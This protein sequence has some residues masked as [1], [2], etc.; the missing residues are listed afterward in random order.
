MV[1]HGEQKFYKVWPWSTILAM[2]NHGQDNDFI[3]V[4]DGWLWTNMVDQQKPS[5]TVV[6]MVDHGHY[7]A[8]E[9]CTVYPKRMIKYRTDG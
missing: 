5:K 8:W 3:M 2:V 9:I 4:F 6:T 1:N 7:F